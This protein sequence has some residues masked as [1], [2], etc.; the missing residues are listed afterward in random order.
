MKKS[1]KLLSVL[2]RRAEREA[3]KAEQ[4]LK[5][6]HFTMR[7]HPLYCLSALPWLLICVALAVAFHWM[8]VLYLALICDG[9]ALLLAYLLLDWLTWRAQVNEQGIAVKRW[10]L[11][12]RELEWKEIERARLQGEKSSSSKTL[13]V[14][15]GKTSLRFV[16]EMIGFEP[17]CQ[18]VQTKDK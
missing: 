8:D 11:F 10:G 3:R 5:K 1:E 13:I 12:C 16:S 14:T 7:Y 4:S 6:E 17:L 9:M 15:A 2:E 18:M